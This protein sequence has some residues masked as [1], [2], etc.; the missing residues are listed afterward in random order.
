M[1]GNV[2]ALAAFFAA[3]VAYAAA[4]DLRKRG[5]A[6]L[7]PPLVVLGKYTVPIAEAGGLG[8]PP[9]DLRVVLAKVLGGLENFEIRGL[10]SQFLSRLLA[11]VSESFK[12]ALVSPQEFPAPHS[13]W[14]LYN[15]IWRNAVK[16]TEIAVNTYNQN[17]ALALERLGTELR[18]ALGEGV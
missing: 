11:L 18:R 10:F 16:E 15:D 17:P 5:E 4:V 2:S 1:P 12:S 8:R 7:P 9:E 6:S 3:S 13:Q 14:I